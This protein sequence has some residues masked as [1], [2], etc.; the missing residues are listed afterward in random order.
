MPASYAAS[1]HFPPVRVSSGGGE[2]PA[3]LG[4][5]LGENPA[6]ITKGGLKGSAGSPLVLRYLSSDGQSSDMR[7]DEKTARRALAQGLK[8]D[9]GA[10]G[11]ADAAQR[12]H[13][14]AESLVSL[15]RESGYL[16]DPQSLAD[17]VGGQK[18]LGES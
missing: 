1:G 6:L 17:L 4:R 16:I 3:I 13:R 8:D 10:D 7:S 5:V 2:R 11:G 9:G 18:N 12:L 14:E 15:A